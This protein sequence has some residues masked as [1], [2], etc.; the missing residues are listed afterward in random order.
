MVASLTVLNTGGG[1]ASN[2]QLTSVLLNST[3]TSTTLPNLGSI[4][5]GGSANTSVRFPGGGF[6]S[7]SPAVLRVTG[8]YNGGSFTSTSRVTIP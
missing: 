4:A 3:A 5:A 8:S 6:M 2:V 1:A 7:G